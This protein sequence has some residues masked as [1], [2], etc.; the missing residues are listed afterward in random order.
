MAKTNS[1]RDRLHYI[2]PRLV[3]KTGDFWAA[4]RIHTLCDKWHP[5]GRVTATP[6]EVSCKNCL[7]E[8][9]KLVA[10]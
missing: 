7:R 9:D 3:N 10:A 6:G 8:L 1:S 2:N 5:P 4:A